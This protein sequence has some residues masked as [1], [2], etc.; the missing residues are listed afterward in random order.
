VVLITI[1]I[2]VETTDSYITIIV[3]S[4]VQL[5]QMVCMVMSKLENVTIVLM[6]VDI[7]S[8]HVTLTTLN[9]KLSVNNVKNQNILLLKMIT[10][11]QLAQKP[12]I[13]LNLQSKLVNL[14]SPH[15]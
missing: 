5:T 11:S 2:L 3:N 13:T 6:I 8:N 10:V 9:V 1:V 15:V 4:P 12:T 7:V 14:V